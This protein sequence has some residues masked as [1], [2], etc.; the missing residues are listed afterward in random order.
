VTV[1]MSLRSR[2]PSSLSTTMD[3]QN[4]TLRFV[5][6][7][8]TISRSR[9]HTDVNLSLNSPAS[10]QPNGRALILVGKLASAAV[11]QTKDSLTPHCLPDVQNDF[12]P[13]NGSMGVP[14]GA[15]ILPLVYSLIEDGDWDLICASLDSHPH[16]HISFAS[17][18]PPNEPYTEIQVPL[19]NAKEGGTTAQMLWSVVPRY[20]I[21]YSEARL[22]W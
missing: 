21:L 10:R 14:D 6:G 9:P 22:M 1:G 20:A 13:P 2:H 3:A 19:L 5:L 4:S 16:N 12:I 7:L 8:H 15:A 18:N 17:Q 11:A